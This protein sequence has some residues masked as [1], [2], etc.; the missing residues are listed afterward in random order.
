MG[1]IRFSHN[2]AIGCDTIIE[3]RHDFAI[4]NIEVEHNQL[5]NIRRLIGV[6][7]PPSIREEFGIPH[8]ISDEQLKETAAMVA[9]TPAEAR[10]SVL[11]RNGIGRWAAANGVSIA[12]LVVALVQLGG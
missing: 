9:D 10:E 8:G 12:Q 11:K 5:H 1:S 4:E 7:Q 3:V 6:K 2:V